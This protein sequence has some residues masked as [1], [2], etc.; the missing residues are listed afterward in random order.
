MEDQIQSSTDD[1]CVDVTRIGAGNIVIP[2]INVNE[3]T[4]KELGTLQTSK[5]GE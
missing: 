5:N 1:K 3:A 2:F 4:A